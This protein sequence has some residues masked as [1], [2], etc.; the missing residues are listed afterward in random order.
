M[1]GN[2]M[3]GTCNTHKKDEIGILC[4]IWKTWRKRQLWGPR[5]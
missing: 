1:K 4:V 3:D 5:Q 2:E